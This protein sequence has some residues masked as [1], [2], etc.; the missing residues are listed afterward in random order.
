VT[1]FVAIGRGAVI[2]VTPADSYAKIESAR[3]GDEVVIAPGTYTYRVHLTAHASGSQPI[4]IHAQEPTRR[5]VWDLSATLV[6]N[7]PGSY[8][9]G[10]R[11]RGAWQL[12]GGTGYRISGVEFTGCHT[13]SRNAAGVRYFHGATNLYLSDCLFLGNDNGLTG[14]T[15]NSAATVEFCEFD[16]NGD[17]LATSPTHNMYIYGGVFALRYCYVH[18]CT[19]AENFHV[20]ARDATLEYNWFARAKSYEGDL[21]TDDDFSGAGPFTQ[22]MLVR[23]NVFLQ[24]ANPDNHSQVLVIFNDTGLTNESMSMRVINN[25]FV[26][27]GGSAAFVHLANQDGTE[28]QAEVSNNLISGTTRPSLIDTPARGVVT[29][30]ANWL[31]TG[32]NPGPLTNS[33][34]SAT[35]GFNGVPVKDFTLAPGSAAIGR[36]DATVALPAYEY[37]QNETNARQYR[38]RLTTRD[39]GAFES[40]TTGAGV[41]PYDAPPAPRLVITRVGGVV[42]LAW[43][44]AASDYALEEKSALTGSGGWTPLPLLMI[45]NA[46]G[47]QS[48]A[49][50]SAADAFYRLRKP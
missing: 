16:H 9:A 34:F 23:G 28:M 31:A 11:G 49:Q 35:P 25:T 47:L 37:Y 30:G 33:V 40:A 45:T 12:D 3:A 36:A 20:R 17:P 15:E 22:T 5:P 7:A 2:Q 24:N 48:A 50:I 38:V 26:G 39:I 1:F 18:D 8:T 10:D 32:V 44:L 6:E 13:A 43:P 14:G 42:T 4:L 41:G 29:G 46:S 21:M 19:Q 27:N